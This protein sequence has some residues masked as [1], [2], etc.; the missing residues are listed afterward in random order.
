MI[1]AKMPSVQHN[2]GFWSYRVFQKNVVLIALIAA[3][4]PHVVIFHSLVRWAIFGVLPCWRSGALYGSSS[5]QQ[6][7]DL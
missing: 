6:G 4:I 5:G 1:V 3:L 2:L 7:A